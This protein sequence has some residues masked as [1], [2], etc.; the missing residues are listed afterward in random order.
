[1]LRGADR[2]CD[3]HAQ[4]LEP[5]L[6]RG[7]WSRASPAYRTFHGG[8]MF[9]LD[10]KS[11]TLCSAPFA[12]DIFRVL[13]SVSESAPVMKFKTDVPAAAV[14]QRCWCRLIYGC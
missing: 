6:P 5:V 1:M 3:L 14:P 12:F 8:L 4:S 9:S 2:A 11:P 7:S 13:R 10:S